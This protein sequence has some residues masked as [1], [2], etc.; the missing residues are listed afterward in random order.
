MQAGRVY[1]KFLYIR[2]R[3]SNISSVGIYCAHMRKPKVLGVI[4]ARIGSTRLPRKMLADIHGKPLVWHTW[5][6]ARKAS[7][8]DALVIATD[9]KEIR[10]ALLP[11]GA[12]VVMTSASIRTGTDRVAATA[13][14]FKRFRPDIVLNIQ[15]DEPMLPPVA[16]NDIVK[17]L[18]KNPREVMAT[19]ATRFKTAREINNPGQVKVV[20]DCRGRALY[21]SRSPI[22]YRRGKVMIE[23]LRHIGMYGFRF[24]FLKKFTKLPQTPL[25]KTERLEQLRALESGYSILV[26]FG[27][28]ERVEVNTSEELELVR[29]ALRKNTRAKRR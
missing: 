1:C 10:D 2:H 4:P 17:L 6:Q 21:F 18:I 8:L 27:M 7:S 19:V 24:D 25:E 14:K 3:M 5:N 28:Y 26:G 13:K 23:M 22:P 20:R 29:R 16:V 11:L 9:S 12:E 15:G